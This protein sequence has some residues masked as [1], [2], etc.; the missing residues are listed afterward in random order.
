MFLKIGENLIK[1][2]S[3]VLEMVL[4]SFDKELYEKDLKQIADALE[5]NVGTIQDI[6]AELESV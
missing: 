6:I 2:K 1:R 3:E 5:E 4:Y